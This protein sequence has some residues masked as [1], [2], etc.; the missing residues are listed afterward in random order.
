MI[1]TENEVEGVTSF[2]SKES[3]SI[4]YLIRKIV[5][6]IHPYNDTFCIRSFLKVTISQHLNEIFFFSLRR[7]YCYQ[8]QVKIG[9][10]YNYEKD[11][12]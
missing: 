3:R 1:K 5:Y 12:T 10:Y 9:K 4:L 6:Y 2:A 8:Y 7:K 11:L